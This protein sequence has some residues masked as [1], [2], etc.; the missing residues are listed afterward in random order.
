MT[1]PLIRTHALTRYRADGSFLLHPADLSI[2]S[3]ARIGVHGTSGSGKSMLLRTLALLDWPDGGQLYWQGKNIDT[4]ADI[5]AYRTEAAYV[6]QQPVLLPGSVADNLHLPYT[7]AAYRTRRPDPTHTATLLQVIGR[8]TEFL[9]ADSSHLSGGE[10]Q[11]VCLMRVL[12]L[13]PRVLLLDEPTAALDPQTA[14]A[15]EALLT[16]WYA[17]APQQ[18]AWVWISHSP[19]QQA[20]VADTLWQVQQGQVGIEAN[21]A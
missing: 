21:H 9:Q 3:G 10:A 8:G 17:A 5:R 1:T 15:A 11:L 20:R 12:Q 6:R 4:A 19:E 16:A 14:A 18:R 2:H 13:Q 7:L